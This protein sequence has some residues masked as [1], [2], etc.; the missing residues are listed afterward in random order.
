MTMMMTMTVM[1]GV[2][3]KERAKADAEKLGG[4][5]P[6]AAFIPD[7]VRTTALFAH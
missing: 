3:K 5:D 2:E 4:W 1:L 6:R 7:T